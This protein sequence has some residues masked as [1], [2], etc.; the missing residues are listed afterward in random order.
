MILAIIIFMVAVVVWMWCDT[1]KPFRYPP[2]ESDF[3]QYLIIEKLPEKILTELVH[4]KFDKSRYKLGYRKIC[5]RYTFSN[6]LKYQ[7]VTTFILVS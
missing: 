6:I 3:L 1:R 7:C 2:G 5:R 4:C